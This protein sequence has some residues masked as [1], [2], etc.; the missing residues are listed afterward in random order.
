M[1]ED[2]PFWHT[3]FTNC[4]MEVRLSSHSE[5]SSYEQSACMVMSDNICFPAKLAHSHIQ[6][7]IDSRVDRIFMPFVVYER[8]DGGQNS[9]NCPIVTG[10]AEVVK[11]VQGGN[12]P[13]DSPTI[14]FKDKKRSSGSAANIWRRWELTTRRRAAPSVWQWRRK[15][16]TRGTS[17]HTANTSTARPARK[18]P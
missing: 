14:S 5:F 11:G 18:E 3:L 8:Q 4:G 15:T 12:I 7:L 6:D 2:Y 13:I 17:P 9:Y 1:Y 10:Y 16:L